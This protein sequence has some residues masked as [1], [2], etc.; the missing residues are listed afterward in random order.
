M[1][2]DGIGSVICDLRMIRLINKCEGKWVEQMVAYLATIQPDYGE[3]NLQCVLA[4]ANEL[5]TSII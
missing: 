4:G 3:K 1:I 5:N 2:H